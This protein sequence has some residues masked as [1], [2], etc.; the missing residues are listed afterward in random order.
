MNMFDEISKAEIVDIDVQRKIVF[1]MLNMTFERNQISDMEES[2]LIDYIVKITEF[3]CTL[4]V[5]ES[6]IEHL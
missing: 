6:I 5:K 3:W 4:I 1:E 2:R